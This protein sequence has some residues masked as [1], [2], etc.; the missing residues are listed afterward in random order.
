M[1]RSTTL[2]AAVIGGLV[3]ALTAGCATTAAPEG[4]DAGS[5]QPTFVD[6]VL[7]PLGN[8]FPSGPL[9]IVVVDEAGSDDGIYARQFAEVAAKYTDAEIRVLDRPDFGTYGSW[10][11][12]QWVEQQRGGPDGQYMVVVTIPGSTVDLLTTP[13][14]QDLDVSIETLN[15]VLVTESVPYIITSR[16]DAP[17]GNSFAE[18]ME[19][20]QANPGEVRYISRGP[21][22]GPDLAMA[23]YADALGVEFNTSVGGSHSE[24]NTALGAGAGDVAVTLPGAASPFIQDGTV[25]M[26]TCSGNENPCAANFG[27]EVPNAAGVVGIENDPWGSNR[28]LIAATSVPEENRLWLEALMLAVA[29]DPEFQ[30]LR[31]SIPGV[32]LVTLNKAEALDLQQSAYDLAFEILD[33]L[34][35]IHPSVVR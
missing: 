8:G 27:D 12:L 19:Y 31:T 23:T 34:G 26:L 1:K 15:T 13:V 28:A 17:W 11:A 20:A 5:N 4:D 35:Q 18:M 2:R 7:Q 9:T 3:V 32:G 24:I 10:E 33:G 14:A 30:D 25:V 6:G 16:A 29:E 22:A 21:G